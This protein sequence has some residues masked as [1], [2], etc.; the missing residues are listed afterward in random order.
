MI[1]LAEDS[2]RGKE[3]RGARRREEGGGSFARPSRGAH[4][5]R[6][7]FALFYGTL[8]RSFRIVCSHNN[9]RAGLLVGWLPARGLAGWLAGGTNK[10][11]SIY[12]ASCEIGA[13]EI[14]DGGRES[15]H[16]EWND[17]TRA[18]AK[19]RMYVK[20][21]CVNADPREMMPSPRDFIFAS[22]LRW[23][24]CPSTCG[25]FHRHHYVRFSLSSYVPGFADCLLY[26]VHGMIACVSIRRND[27][28]LMRVARMQKQKSTLMFYN[29]LA[30][31]SA[32]F[33]ILMESRISCGDLKINS[34]LKYRTI[35]I[36]R[37]WCS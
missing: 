21:T 24:L 32:P 22:F 28:W 6:L 13:E 30:Q 31:T 25:C 16:A 7:G 37:I 12:V 36:K 9:L 10:K 14:R 18:V 29:V 35:D 20:N 8:E 1:L 3:E 19:R 4:E 33:L 15:K 34:Y 5:N 2:K 17:E 27:S 26:R 11:C 23:N